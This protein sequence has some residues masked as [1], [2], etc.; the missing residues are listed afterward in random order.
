VQGKLD[1]AVREYEITLQLLPGSAQAHFRLGQALE[2]QRHFAAAIAEFQK[3]LDLEPRHL[4]AHLAL[5]WL[6]ATC[7]EAS[8]RDGKQAV[9]LA[10]QARALA[11]TESPQLLDTLA[12]AY[13]EAGKFELAAATVRRALDVPAIQNDRPLAE[14]IRAR[15]KLYE[16]N[17][18]Y[19]E[20]P[21]PSPR[22]AQ[23]DVA[24]P[25][26]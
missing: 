2:K 20:P 12:A 26:R 19:H 14:A 25:K 7:P 17:I 5:A 8:L 4:P 22:D 9:A 10:E 15:L 1:E 11:G 3:A 23:S 18:P 16:A 24:L 6:L 13:A 21:Q